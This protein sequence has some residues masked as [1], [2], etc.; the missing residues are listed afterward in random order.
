MKFRIVFKWGDGRREV[1]SGKGPYHIGE[2]FWLDE[3]LELDDLN[4]VYWI[5]FHQI[6]FVEKLK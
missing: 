2:G 5:P 6:Q 1:I 3:N 4:N